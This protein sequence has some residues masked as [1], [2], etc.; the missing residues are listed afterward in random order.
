MRINRRTRGLQPSS[1]FVTV[2][3]VSLGVARLQGNSSYRIHSIGFLVGDRG[4]LDPIYF[5]ALYIDSIC[6]TDKMLILLF[7]DSIITVKQLGM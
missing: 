5:G 4:G 3:V 7:S 6:E 2:Q 1:A